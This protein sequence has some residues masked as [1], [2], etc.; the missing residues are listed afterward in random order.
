MENVSYTAQWTAAARA[1]ESDRDADPLFV[2][3]YAKDLA[4]PRGFEL[5][6]KYRGGGVAEFVA[7]RTRYIDDSVRA[8]MST[9]PIAQ[10]VLVASGMDT[11]VYRMDWPAGTTVYEI[12]HPDLLIEK[13]SRMAEL[14]ASPVVP[15]VELG[16]D[17]A[18]DWRTPLRSHGFDP[19]RPTL[20][21]V[22][23]LL[24]F[25]TEEQ[26]AGLLL[27]MAEVSAPGSTLAGDMTSATLLRHPM[28]QMF[29]ATL[30]ADGTPWRFG[31]DDPV[32]FLA[33]HGWTVR[34]LKEPG[35]PGAGEGRWPYQLAAR[36]VRGV[37]RNWLIN[38]V[39]TAPA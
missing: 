13:Q 34:D 22:E 25:L 12:D 24:F 33:D 32:G 10:V 28:T 6:E 31:T 18:S 8:V 26:A 4:A 21:V 3:E 2:D 1:L 38:A 35:Q 14:S 7:I 20:W 30:R 17:L 37:P 9:E 5:L 23:G 16:V 19:D 15:T 27:G 39:A 36:E 11:R 29:L